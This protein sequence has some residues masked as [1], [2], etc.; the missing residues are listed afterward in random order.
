MQTVAR[1]LPP[2]QVEER[3]VSPKDEVKLVDSDRARELSHPLDEPSRVERRLEPYERGRDAP[4][5]GAAEVDG[6]DGCTVEVG[7][8][9]VEQVALEH[10]VRVCADA[11]VGDDE[12]GVVVHEGVVTHVGE[13]LSRR[14]ALVDEKSFSSKLQSYGHPEE[15]DLPDGLEGK[16]RWEQRE[17]REWEGRGCNGLR[18]CVDLHPSNHMSI[19]KTSHSHYGG[20]GPTEGCTARWGTL[21]R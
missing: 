18:G 9:V 1:R 5:E 6:Q 7:F 16:M 17:A 10:R 2:T 12:L 4:G 15:I 11:D 19:H 3:L 21:R 8:E 14:V 13:A 20:W